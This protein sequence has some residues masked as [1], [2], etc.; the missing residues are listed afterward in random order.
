MIPINLDAKLNRTALA[1]ALTPAGYD[2]TASTLAGLAHRGGGPDYDLFNGRARYT[3][4]PSLK[5]AESRVKAPRRRAY[6]HA[7]PAQAA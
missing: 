2:I 1:E 4:G 3:W 6:S 5:W 7:E